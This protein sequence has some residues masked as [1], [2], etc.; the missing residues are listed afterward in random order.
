MGLLVAIAKLFRLRWG[1]QQGRQLVTKAQLTPYGEEIC[2][3]VHSI[4]TF[5]A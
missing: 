2:V 1:G 5:S 4:S 3:R